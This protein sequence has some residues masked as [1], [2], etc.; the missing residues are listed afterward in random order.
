MILML[1]FILSGALCYAHDGVR[2]EKGKDAGIPVEIIE[3]TNIS[4]LA[5]GNAIIPVLNGHFLTVTFSENMG[6]VLVEVSTAAGTSVE[7]LSVY[8]PNGVQVYIPNA[9]NYIVTF[10]F[11]DGDVYAGEFTV[12]D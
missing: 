5:K 3:S 7:S 4:G 8:T 1:C 9:G 11:S 12:T 6:Q 10:T 2:T